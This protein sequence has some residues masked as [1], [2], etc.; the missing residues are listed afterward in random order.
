[1][2]LLQYRTISQDNTVARP[3]PKCMRVSNSRWFMQKMLAT[4]QFLFHADEKNVLKKN[5]RQ[6]L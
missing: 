3:S 1:M 2:K 6:V 5:T 4:Q